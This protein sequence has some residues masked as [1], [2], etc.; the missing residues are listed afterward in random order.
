MAH[1]KCLIKLAT[2][3]LLLTFVLLVYFPD[4]SNGP[5]RLISIKNVIHLSNLKSN[6]ENLLFIRGCAVAT[7]MKR[8]Q[9]LPLRNWEVS[10][11]TG[12]GRGKHSVQGN[13]R[14]SGGSYS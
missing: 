10:E 5:P 8:S 3:I 7:K 9:S 2:G 6:F 13:P 1:S 4:I 12:V 11:E 14:A